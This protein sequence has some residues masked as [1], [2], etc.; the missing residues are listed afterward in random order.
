[1]IDRPFQADILNACG[2]PALPGTWMVVFY[3]LSSLDKH[4]SQD[5]LPKQ[6]GSEQNQRYINHLE[7]VLLHGALDG[8]HHHDMAV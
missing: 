3:E 6:G 5:R 8:A 7:T 2:A 1:M 4:S